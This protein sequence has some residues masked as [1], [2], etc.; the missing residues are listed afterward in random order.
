VAFLSVVPNE[1]SLLVG[2]E[3]KAASKALKK[4]IFTMVLL[5]PSN[6]LPLEPRALFPRATTTLSR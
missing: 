4:G 1:R 5:Y 2:V 6:S 3:E